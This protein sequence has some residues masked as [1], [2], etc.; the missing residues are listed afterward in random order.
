MRR[1]LPVLGV[2]LALAVP[3]LLTLMSVRVVMTPLFLQLEYNRPGFPP[4]RFGLTLE[5]RLFYAPFAV[6][7]LLNGEDIEYLA[8]LTFPDGSPLYTERELRHME[9]VKV[10]TQIAFRVL[11][12]GGLATL[13]LSVWLAGSPERR[14]VLLRGLFAGGALT[15]TLIA[16][17]VIGAVVAWR[18]FFT[19]FHQ[20]FFEDGT[21]VFLFSDTLIRLFPEQFWFD[22]ALTI[23]ILTA[24][25][26][27]QVMLVSGWLLRQ[28]RS[29]RMNKG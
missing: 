19:L 1:V 8:R 16:L 5:E 11:F 12:F 18:E 2:L 10:V 29:M 20:L 23:G 9:D 21:W 15:L 28:R 27:A 13:A 7:Y 3:V 25:L 22:A 14:P 6:E 17:I 26:A 4:D 24:M